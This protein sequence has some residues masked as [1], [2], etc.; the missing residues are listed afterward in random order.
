LGRIKLVGVFGLVLGTVAE[1]V[2]DPGVGDGK[3]GG[4]LQDAK[5]MTPAK[6]SCLQCMIQGVYAWD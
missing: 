1:V 3:V 2:L 6:P 5:E 4:E